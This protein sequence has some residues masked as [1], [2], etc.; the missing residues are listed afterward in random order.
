MFPSQILPEVYWIHKIFLKK[1]YSY[2]FRNI[3][4]KAPV[5][6]SLFNKVAGLHVCNFIKK[7]LQY[8]S[9][10]VKIAKEHLQTAASRRY[11]H[12]V[13]H[14]GF[15]VKPIITFKIMI[16]H[17]SGNILKGKYF[18]MDILMTLHALPVN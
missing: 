2:K 12:F 14:T 5:L 11:N 10:S 16:K 4:R 17:L 1:S 13:T 9:F 6:E 15:L 3:H 8:R 7:R 18:G